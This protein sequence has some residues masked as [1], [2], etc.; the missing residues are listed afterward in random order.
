VF[1]FILAEAAVLCIAA[2]AFGL[3]L[4][5]LAFPFATKWVP[6]L[7]MPMVVVA[8][9]LACAA[10]VAVISASIPAILAARLNIVTALASR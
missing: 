4:A 3:A 10:L 1:I 9:G 6:G 7:S 8:A 5:S 2:A